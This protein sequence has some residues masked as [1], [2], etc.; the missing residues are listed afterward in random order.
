MADALER[1]RAVTL[2]LLSLAF[3]YTATI[4][5]SAKPFWHDEIYTLVL[6]SLPSFSTMWAALRGG[7][8]LA[9]PLNAVLTR[10]VQSLLGTGHVVSRLVPMISFWAMTMALFA[11]VHRRANA[12]VALTAALFPINTAAYRHS[13]E[14]R[15]Y[16]LMMALFTLA[17]FAWAEAAAG[18]RR[19][20]YLPLLSLAL[21]AGLWN[22]YYAV[23][24]YLPVITGE[25]TRALRRRRMDLG[26]LCA[27]IVSGVA[28][29]P[30]FQLLSG[31]AQQ[32]SS[33][34]AQASL[35]D[36]GDAFYFLTEPLLTPSIFVTSGVVVILAFLAWVVRGRLD[37]VEQRSIP[38][39]EI[40]AGVACLLVPLAG[41]LL[42]V[43][44]T[45]V[46]VPRYVLTGV[47][48]LSLVI[49]LTVWSISARARIVEIAFPLV[50]VVGYMQ[51]FMP[52][53]K[54]PHP[55]NSRPTLVASLR[56]P[57]PTAVTGGLTYLQ[58]WYYA[59]TDLKPRLTYIADPHYARRY[60]GS[61]TFDLGYLT[62]A[63]WTAVNVAR[64]DSFTANHREF[65]V[66]AF[67][68]GWLL[69]KLQDADA[70]ID[71]L[72]SDPG[73]R[74]LH[75]RLSLGKDRR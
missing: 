24:A 65:R 50:F 20:L 13:Y 37:V 38:A 22:H 31:G 33:Y 67:G 56:S 47:V 35:D 16:G 51:L 73:A 9:P 57:G 8:D 63:R 40:A 49:P 11:M 19:R 75:V 52:V 30:L 53:T 59:P 6:T 28:A 26:V 12:T 69:H 18:R 7:L 34:W 4:R 23:F 71:T 62:L 36:I 10:A 43:F 17:L 72:G 15:P 68:S 70:Q 45:G 74:L 2:V 46:F 3:F 42:G 58:L 14:A 66:Y 39:H 27:I 48:G 64:F 5:A 41:V 21:S 55:V 25:L 60:T 1:H 54:L 44:V 32:A 29:L 61:D